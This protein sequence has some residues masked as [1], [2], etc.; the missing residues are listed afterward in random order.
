LISRFDVRTVQPDTTDQKI[1]ATLPETCRFLYM[2][3]SF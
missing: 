3:S 1:I 2:H